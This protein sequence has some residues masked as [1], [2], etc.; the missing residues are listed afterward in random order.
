MV[1]K[2]QTIT[3]ISLYAILAIVASF[4]F[5]YQAGSLPKHIFGDGFYM[6]SPWLTLAV[7]ML[8]LLPLSCGFTYGFSLLYFKTARKTKCRW[9]NACMC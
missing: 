6:I 5:I 3:S 4:T 8:L 7:V 2:I 1:K 9:I